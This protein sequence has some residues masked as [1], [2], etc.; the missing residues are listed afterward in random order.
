MNLHLER[1]PSATPAVVTRLAAIGRETFA[2]TFAE[3][4]DPEELRRYLDEA[5]APQQVAQELNN[6]DS[7]FY[8]LTDGAGR[9]LGYLK[10]NLPPAFSDAVTLDGKALEVQRIY[11][12]PETQGQGAGRLMMD[13]AVRVAQQHGC[14]WLWLGVWEH[15][16][17]AIGFYERQGFEPFD[18]H[19][20]MFGSE[21]Q[22]D[23]LMRRQI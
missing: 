21:A 2:V 11:L 9:D 6:P 16:V 12:L 19:T 17:Q 1:V 3:N 22:T 18:Q 14:K 15:N 8:L 23:V 10:L 13:E 4:N 7:F 20:F 5:F